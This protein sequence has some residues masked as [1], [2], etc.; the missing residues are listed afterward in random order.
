MGGPIHNFQHRHFHRICASH[1]Q[2]DHLQPIRRPKRPVLPLQGAD[3]HRDK[4]VLHME[5]RAVD[6]DDGVQSVHL[7]LLQ[8]PINHLPHCPGSVNPVES[9]LRVLYD[10]LL[11][12]ACADC[13]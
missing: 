1:V 12:H 2:A 7:L 9:V 3:K 5:L 10:N 11:H 4:N 13:H 8:V 6:L